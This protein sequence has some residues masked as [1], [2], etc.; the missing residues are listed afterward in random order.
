MSQVGT[1]IALRLNND[2]D[3]SSVGSALPDNLSGL[4][5]SLPSLRTGEAI[6]S[7]E[8]LPI[9][10]RVR[11]QKPNPWPLSHDPEITAWA[12][13]PRSQ[14]DLNKSLAKWRVSS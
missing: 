14:L 10:S 5:Q 6:V 11:M 9:P 7:G 2:A 4:V 13:A 3:Q 12:Q 8:A 1:I